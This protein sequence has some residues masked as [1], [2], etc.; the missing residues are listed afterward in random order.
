MFGVDF[1]SQNLESAD[2]LKTLFSYPLFHKIRS[3]YRKAIGTVH[4]EYLCDLLVHD[5]ILWRR[6]GKIRF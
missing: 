1:F 4:P 5:L 2:D 6:A 3:S